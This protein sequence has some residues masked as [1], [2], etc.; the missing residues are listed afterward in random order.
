MSLGHTVMQMKLNMN[1]YIQW[2]PVWDTRPGKANPYFTDCGYFLLSSHRPSNADLAMQWTSSF[3]NTNT[4]IHKHTNTQI[5]NPQTK[6][7]RPCHFQSTLK[8][9]NEENHQSSC[10]FHVT[11]SAKS[12]RYTVINFNFQHHIMW[13]DQK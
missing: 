6:Q 2:F 8:R 1:K 4:Q 13:H 12:D 7:Y 9:C 5:Q 3:T 11:N 10:S